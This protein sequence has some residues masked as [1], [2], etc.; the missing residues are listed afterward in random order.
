MKEQANTHVDSELSCALKACIHKESFSKCHCLFSARVNA[1]SEL[2]GCLRLSS[3]ASFFLIS[4]P[5][6]FLCSCLR[7]FQV[8]IVSAS[9]FQRARQCHFSQTEQSQSRKLELKL[10]ENTRKKSSKMTTWKKERNYRST[11]EAIELCVCMHGFYTW[12]FLFV[13]CSAN[14]N[15]SNSHLQASQ[16][17]CFSHLF[18]GS[19]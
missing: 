8:E 18:P 16:R 11:F 1:F 5:R 12:I 9:T 2:F 17:I 14:V 10:V 13:W 4:E 19:L 3:S 15:T 7:A 6:L